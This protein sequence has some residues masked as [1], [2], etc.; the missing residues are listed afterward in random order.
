[1]FTAI[2]QTILP[3]LQLALSTVAGVLTG[4]FGGALSYIKDQLQVVINVFK[5]IIDFVKNVFTGNW[6]AAWEN[7]KNIF[8]NIAQAIG[9]VFKAPINFIID[10]INGFIKGLNKIKIPD[11]VPG[12]GGK[13][14]NIALLKKLRVGIDYVPYDEMPALL[15]KGEAVLTSEENKEYQASKNNKQESTNIVYN[16]SITI[17]KLE[18]REEADIERIAQELYYLQKKEVGA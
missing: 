5:N 6:K 1:M 14:I 10:A 9:N 16:N 18:V 11:W 12:V 7:V 13:G 15:H 4:V 17:E 8:A 2:L 3:P